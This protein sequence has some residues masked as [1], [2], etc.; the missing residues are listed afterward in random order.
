MDTDST[1]PAWQVTQ[2][3]EVTDLGPSGAYVAGVKVTF[4]T[5]AGAVGS[6]FLPHDAYG[7]EQVRKAISERAAT[8]DA[9]ARLQG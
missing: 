6:V 5:A 2:Q 1:A 9:V 3:Q 8:L 7:V 4:R